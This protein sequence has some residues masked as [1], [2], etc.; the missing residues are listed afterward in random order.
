MLVQRVD[1]IRRTNLFNEW[2]HSFRKTPST[3]ESIDSTKEQCRHVHPEEIDTEE[4][5]Y[6]MNIQTSMW[7]SHFTLHTH[8]MIS[9][10]DEYLWEKCPKKCR[11]FDLLTSSR[12]V[13]WM[14]STRCDVVYSMNYQWMNVGTSRSA[15][16]RAE[17]I[18]GL[19]ILEDRLSLLCFNSTRDHRVIRIDLNNRQNLWKKQTLDA[20]R[21]ESNWETVTG[22]LLVPLFRSLRFFDKDPFF[23]DWLIERTE[24]RE[25]ES[26]EE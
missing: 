22:H 19:I 9:Y 1:V 10:A 16:T 23:L 11:H 20:F 13:E 25:G 17:S 2:F 14:T 26:I 5:F 24:W 18:E 15:K 12:I 21:R 8:A 6:S 4:D 3:S 7:C